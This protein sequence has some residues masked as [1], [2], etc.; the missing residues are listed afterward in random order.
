MPEYK[1]AEVKKARGMWPLYGL[2]MAI[3]AGGIAYVLAPR[4]LEYIYSRSANFGIGSLTTNQ[5]ELFI[6]AIIF[7]ILVSLGGLIVAIFMPKRK[8]DSVQ[9]AFLKKQKDQMVKD[10]KARRVR[11]AMIERELKKN[12]K[13]MS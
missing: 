4:V 12:N 8:E 13:R 5:V 10:E 11:K 2:L 7:F 3:A 1:K 6:G 9:D